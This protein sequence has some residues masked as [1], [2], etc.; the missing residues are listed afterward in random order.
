MDARACA[1]LEADPDC[2]PMN[3]H[4]SRIAQFMT[5]K[6]D[7]GQAQV[8]LDPQARKSV[9]RALT[10]IQRTIAGA[11]PNA[12]R[13]ED[14]RQADAILTTLIS[15]LLI[16]HLKF[17]AV[18]AENLRRDGDAVGYYERAIAELDKLTARDVSA[19]REELLRHANALKL[20]LTQDTAA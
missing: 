16:D 20:K 19:E 8:T 17:A 9:R 18:S 2:S 5:A 14:R 4:R 13:E 11:A 15:R 1:A 7:P 10:V 6:A 3:D 12:I